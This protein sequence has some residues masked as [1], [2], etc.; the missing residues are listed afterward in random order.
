MKRVWTILAALLL[1]AVT[2]EAGNPLKVSK[3]VFDTYVIETGDL[4]YEKGISYTFKFPYRNQGEGELLITAIVPGCYCV[5]PEHSD[6]PLKMGQ[7]DTVTVTFNPYKSGKFRH[8]L[9]I[10]TNGEPEL[11]YVTFRGNL[12]E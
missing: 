7:T 3:P 11:L 6:Q 1:G 10:C 8:R 12:T 4:P 2:I 5:V 9:A